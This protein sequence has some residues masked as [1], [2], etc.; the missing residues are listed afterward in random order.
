ML[1]NGKPYEGK[2]PISVTNLLK[3]LG[4]NEGFVAV[5]INLKICKKA[6]YCNTF[7]NDDDN[8]E[9]VKLVQ[10]G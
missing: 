6:N 7:L 3:N 5:E 10:G 8:V 4:Y 9:I 2:T 1:V